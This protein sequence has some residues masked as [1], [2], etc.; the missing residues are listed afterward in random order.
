MKIQI[1][2]FMRFLLKL[3]LLT[4]LLLTQQSVRAELDGYSVQVTGNFLLIIP[5]NGSHQMPLVDFMRRLERVV[6]Q[7]GNFANSQDCK[8]FTVRLNEKLPQGFCRFTTHQDA[9][10]KVLEISADL[11]ALL[12]EPEVGRTIT[13]A[14]VQSRMGNAPERELPPEAYWIADGLWAEF[15]QREV[16][17]FPVLNFTYLAELRNQVENGFPVRLDLNALTPPAAPRYHS[18]EWVLYTQ[19]AQLMI[20]IA[21]SCAV[22]RHDN[23][24]KDY[25][26][27]LAG[28]QIAAS[29]ACE[30][31]FAQA[32]HRKL[33]KSAPRQR[34]NL[35]KADP[36][37]AQ[38]SLDKLVW[39]NLFSSYAPVS[40]ALCSKFLAEIE[41]VTY[42]HERSKQTMK[43]H[44]A[45]LPALVQKYDSCAALPRLKI[46]QINELVLIAPMQ[47]RMELL[48]LSEI[49]ANLA[50]T[51]PQ[52]SAQEIKSTL[53]SLKQRLKYL[54]RIDLH[55][56]KYEQTMHSPLYYERYSIGGEFAPAPLPREIKE[57]I[58]RFDS[59]KH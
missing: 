3:S 55:L 11:A 21:N 38:L 36:A 33:A 16:M 10:G 48:R 9:D 37:V 20:K 5:E 59:N 51:A 2:F 19:K 28:G 45:D 17:V 56:R 25:C 26:F 57:Y 35:P 27:L 44:L 43:A 49:L 47:L 15:V 52:Q 40:A 54:D 7:Y 30:L 12:R 24:L 6:R 23:L 46:D 13:A 58:D 32:A 4:A 18:A 42:Q 8:P 53:V 39:R 29:E 41:L 22:K 34:K 50:K 1:G 14:L 31:T